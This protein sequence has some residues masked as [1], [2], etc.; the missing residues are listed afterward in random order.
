MKARTQIYTVKGAGKFLTSIP[1]RLSVY[2]CGREYSE[3]SGCVKVSFFLYYLIRNV[4]H[5][6]FKRNKN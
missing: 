1:H 5:L 2:D 3:T 6:F 4:W